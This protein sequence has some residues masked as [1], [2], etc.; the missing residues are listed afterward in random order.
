[1]LR[2]QLFIGAI[3]H[4][5]DCQSLLTPTLANLP[6]QQPIATS[7]HLLNGKQL[8]YCHGYHALICV[9]E[10]KREGGGE[11]KGERERLI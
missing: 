11:G 7:L 4:L 10:E 5:A 3:L 2:W 8:I 6:N 9:C 1:M